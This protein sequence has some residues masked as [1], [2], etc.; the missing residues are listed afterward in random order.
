MSRTASLRAR[1]IVN[2]IRTRLTRYGAA[3]I[4]VVVAI[5]LR[6]WLHPMMGHQSVAIF[7]G[8]ILA[9][10]WIGGIGPA[11]LCLVLLHLIHGYWYE[12][13][14]RLWAPTMSSII[15]TGGY[16]V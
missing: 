8:G 13:P 1:V 3:L 12:T 11:L 6:A 16:Y 2:A 10:A 4:F 5:A 7:M 15:G 14:P 9:G